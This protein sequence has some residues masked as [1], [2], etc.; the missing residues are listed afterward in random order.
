MRTHKAYFILILL[1]LAFA[2]GCGGKE[3]A[4]VTV[5]AAPVEHTPAPTAAP[6]SVPAP[7]ATPQEVS[8]S[9][10]TPTPTPS[11][12]PTPSPTPEP[13]LGEWVYSFEGT[14]IVLLLNAGGDGTIRYGDN[15]QAFTW[16]FEGGSLMLTGTRTAF[17]AELSGNTL[18]VSTADGTL[19][20]TGK[21][22]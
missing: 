15:E 22:R 9:V 16:T 13:F 12:V 21:E 11:P 3:E 1:L 5:T 17:K 6:T 19:T 20:F 18:T 7:P 4:P 14:D 10:H 2:M 8:I